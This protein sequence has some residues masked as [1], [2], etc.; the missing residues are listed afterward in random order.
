MGDIISEELVF[1]LRTKGEELAMQRQAGGG[2]EWCLGDQSREGVHGKKTPK[3]K[4]GL[5]TARK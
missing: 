5:V 4:R 1:D 2:E 3:L